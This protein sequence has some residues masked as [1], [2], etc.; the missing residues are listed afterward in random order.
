[1][2]LEYTINVQEVE[3]LQTINDREAL[4]AIFERARR[5][6]VGG[7]AVLLVRK[8][9]KFEEL[10]AEGDLEAYRQQVFKYLGA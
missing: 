9:T 10:T 1:M 4:E 8:G 7:G 2:N 5:T 6:V 3:D